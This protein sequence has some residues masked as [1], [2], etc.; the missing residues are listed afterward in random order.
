MR[1]CLLIHV[2]CMFHDFG[3]QVLDCC[4]RFPTVID[5]FLIFVAGSQQIL[6]SGLQTTEKAL[7]QE[8]PL[9]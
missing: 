2:G 3:L 8:V 9:V 4:L 7:M 6:K 5:V 1:V